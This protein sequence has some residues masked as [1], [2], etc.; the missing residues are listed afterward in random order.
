MDTGS[1]VSVRTTILHH[2]KIIYNK[3]SHSDIPI[4][5]S[6]TSYTDYLTKNINTLISKF[7]IEF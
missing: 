5:D 3:L 1:E 6:Y 4:Y 2:F 7:T